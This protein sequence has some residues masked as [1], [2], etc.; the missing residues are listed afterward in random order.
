[1]AF[2]GGQAV[3]NLL[4][5][6]RNLYT[7]Q[8]SRN[9]AV[10][11][12]GNGNQHL[13]QGVGQLAGSHRHT[14]SNRIEQWIIG[15]R[16]NKGNLSTTFNSR[17]QPLSQQGV[18]LTQEGTYDQNAIQLVQGGQRHTQPRYT[19]QGAIQT[20]ISLTQTEVHVFGTQSTTQTSQQSQFFGSGGS[21]TNTAQLICTKLLAHGIHAGNDG[22][23]GVVP[24]S[25]TPLAVITT[26]H[27]ASQT[28]FGVQAFV[29]ETVTVADPALVDFV[30]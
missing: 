26:H 29:G 4:S 8:T 7:F 28:V 21:R 6:S 18:I 12:F 11:G 30:V 23:H 5:F 2:A 16:I 14:A 25:F 20:S 9:G 19:G 13:S 3:S 15:S 27:G 22:L 1:H 24:G 10:L 17:T